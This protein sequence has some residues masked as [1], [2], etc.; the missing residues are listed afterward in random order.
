MADNEDISDVINPSFPTGRV[1][2]IV[3]IDN[4]INRISSEALF[5]ISG[6]TELFLQFLAEKS[7]QIAAEKK[8][9]TVKIDHL[10]LAVKRHHPTRDFLF[11]SL[12]LPSQPPDRPATADRTVKEKPAPPNTRPIDSF[13]RKPQREEGPSRVNESDNLESNDVDDS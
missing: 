5:L 11:D 12:T 4:D 6:A 8:R 2:K 13:F 9:K 7:A 1:K 10:R 3:K